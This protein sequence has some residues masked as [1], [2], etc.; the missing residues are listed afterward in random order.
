[1]TFQ[2]LSP[3]A[4]RRYDP[5]A[6]RLLQ[7]LP[8]GGDVAVV[9]V[10]RIDGFQ[11][12]ADL[13]LIIGGRPWVLVDFSEFS[14]DWDQQSSYLW[15]RDRTEH[16]WFRGDEYRKLDQF[17]RDNPPVLTFQRELL[18][19]DASEYVL[20]IEYA[21]YSPRVEPDTEERFHARPISVLFN[22]GR[23]S[24]TRPRLHGNIFRESG[25]YGYEVCSQWDHID[26]A[27][28]DKGDR[29]LWCAIH[30][31]HY[32]RVDVSETIRRFSQAKITVAMPGCGRKNFRNGEINNSLQVILGDKLAWG[33]CPA[34]A[35]MLE[36]SEV[37][38]INGLLANGGGNYAAYRRS[39]AASDALRPERYLREYV[40]PAIQKSLC[41]S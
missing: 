21:N 19:G 36:G 33:V 11:F 9:L 23:S 18:R 29:Q 4:Q 37:E 20:P 34:G 5:P 26:R 6:M 14:W 10:T 16:E 39:H 13:K 27:I 31:P 35:H 28:A 32:A 24:E 8:Q 12:R 25:R 3:D 15:G 22:W 41:K 7:C 2:I 1:M 40:V 17:I 30:T 38:E